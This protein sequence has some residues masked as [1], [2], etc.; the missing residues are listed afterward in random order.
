MDERDHRR[1]ADA[2]DPPA[3]DIQHRHPHEFGEEEE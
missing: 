2:P 3:F 1:V